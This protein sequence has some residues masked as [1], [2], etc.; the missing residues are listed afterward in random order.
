MNEIIENLLTRRSTRAYKEEQI[1]DSDLELILEAAK[2]APSGMNSQTW[3]FTVVQNK[4]KLQELNKVVKEALANSAEENFR[5][6]GN[7]PNFHFFYN[8]P[9]FII[10]SN[11]KN[12]PIA[13]PD[14]AVALQNIFLAANSLNISSCWIHM[15]VSVCNVP[16]VRSLLTELGVPENNDIYGSAAIGYSA[17]DNAPKAPERKAGTVNIVK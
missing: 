10:V 4:E 17:A 5:K 16:E 8:A 11:A 2:F 9:T 13:G 6:I 7:N 15:L 3:H 1:K 14:S 12:S